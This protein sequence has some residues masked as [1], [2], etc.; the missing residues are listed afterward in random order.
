MLS[1]AAKYNTVMKQ[2]YSIWLSYSIKQ[3]Y[4]VSEV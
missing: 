3:L 4:I 2:E 1:Y